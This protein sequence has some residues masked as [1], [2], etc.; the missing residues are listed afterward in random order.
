LGLGGPRGKGRGHHPWGHDPGPGLDAGHEAHQ[1]RVRRRTPASHEG[2]PSDARWAPGLGGTAMG[3]GG[4]APGGIFWTTG[5]VP[6]SF[7]NEKRGPL[8]SRGNSTC[9]PIGRS[10]GWG[11][12]A[13]A[14]RGMMVDD[15]VSE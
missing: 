15:L 12:A 1:L 4:T 14:G 10:M 11:W 6:V 2:P 3:L 8:E 13:S 9:R 5:K 7:D